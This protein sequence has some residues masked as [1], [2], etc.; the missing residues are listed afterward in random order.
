MTDP[1]VLKSS[2]DRTPGTNRAGRDQASRIG[3]AERVGRGLARDLAI[4]SMRNTIAKSS[5]ATSLR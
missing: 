3:A 1:P 5:T 2:P 4:R